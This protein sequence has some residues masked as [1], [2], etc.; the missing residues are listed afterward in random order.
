MNNS[1]VRSKLGQVMVLQAFEEL[2]G[3]GSAASPPVLWLPPCPGRGRAGTGPGARPWLCWWSSR[4]AGR[5]S[6]VLPALQKSQ[7]M[8]YNPSAKSCTEL[9]QPHI[10]HTSRICHTKHFPGG[11]SASSTEQSNKWHLQGS[12]EANKG[13]HRGLGAPASAQHCLSLQLPTYHQLQLPQARF[14]M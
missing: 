7:N 8:K 6:G 2:P 14:K 12:P 9:E 1:S 3:A 4:R 10:T 13:V 11:F 5:T